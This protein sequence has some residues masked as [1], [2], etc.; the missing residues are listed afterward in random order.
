[1]GVIVVEAGQDAFSAQVDGLGLRTGMFHDLGVA[2]DS[3]KLAVLDR[4][5]RRRRIGAVKRGHESVVEDEVG[6]HHSIP[7]ELGGL[8]YAGEELSPPGPAAGG[9]R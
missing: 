8:R 4:N 6:I 5:R 7:S 9:A 3:E 1:M 2:A